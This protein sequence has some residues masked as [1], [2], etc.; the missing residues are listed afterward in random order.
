[1]LIWLNLQTKI[2]VLFL[3]L[4]AFVNNGEMINWTNGKTVNWNRWTKQSFRKLYVFKTPGPFLAHFIELFGT[5]GMSFDSGVQSMNSNYKAVFIYT[6]VLI[7]YLKSPS[8]FRS[9]MKTW[10]LFNTP[11]V[12][13]DRTDISNFDL[14]S[15]S[16]IFQD[17]L[18]NSVHA[19]SLQRWILH[20]TLLQSIQWSQQFF[21]VL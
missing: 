21:A 16:K 18:A 3:L 4:S 17:V 10:Q 13:L 20:T 8:G 6:D 19:I 7:F 15:S 12:L 14:F 1:M 2:D 9:T 11:I 5:K